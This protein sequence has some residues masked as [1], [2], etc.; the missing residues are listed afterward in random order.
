MELDDLRYIAANPRHVALVR[1]L[2][3]LSAIKLKG[4]F[5]IAVIVC[6]VDNRKIQFDEQ[7]VDD[8]VFQSPI[9]Y[10][11]LAVHPAAQWSDAAKLE[12]I[13]F[14]ERVMRIVVVVATFDLE[15]F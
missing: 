1:D 5:Q 10:L 6:R 12:L 14:S 2:N 11:P 8:G 3:V 7:L 15:L 13:V 4:R 9:C